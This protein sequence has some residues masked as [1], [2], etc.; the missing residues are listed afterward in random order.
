VLFTGTVRDQSDGRTGVEWLE[1]E[2][3][4]EQV[5]PKLRAICAEARARW[6]D[7]GPIALLHRVGRLELTEVA[8]VVAVGAPHRAE[9]FAAARFAIDSLKASAPIWK[10]ESW[11]GGEQWGTGAQPVSSAAT[12]QFDVVGPE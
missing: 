7:V 9:A 2:A 3:Y 12:V 10:K 6:S 4:T 1:Y 11:Q 5:E 8:V